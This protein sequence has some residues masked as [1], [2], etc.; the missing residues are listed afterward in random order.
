MPYYITQSTVDE[1]L[2]R[3]DSYLTRLIALQNECPCMDIE[4]RDAFELIEEIHALR[5]TQTLKGGRHE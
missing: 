2:A 3:I 1:A 4:A 5:I